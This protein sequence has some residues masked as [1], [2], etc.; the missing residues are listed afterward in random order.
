VIDYLK[1]LL[2]LPLPNMDHEVSENEENYYVS[3]TSKTAFIHFIIN[4]KTGQQMEPLRGTY[5]VTPNSITPDIEIEI[6]PLIE[7]KE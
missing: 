3:A 5:L 1:R 7:I 4:K 2:N 6:D